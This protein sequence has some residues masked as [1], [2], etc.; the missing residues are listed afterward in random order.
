[1][2]VC[3]SEKITLSILTDFLQNFYQRGVLLDF[4]DT[5][6]KTFKSLLMIILMRNNKT[7]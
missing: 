5:F 2:N 4:V 3:L 1:M 7:V 6:G